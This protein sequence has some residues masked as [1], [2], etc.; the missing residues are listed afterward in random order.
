MPLRARH[1]HAQPLHVGTGVFL[2]HVFD[3]AA[4]QTARRSSRT[5][6]IATW[7]GMV[8]GFRFT[9]DP[10]ANNQFLPINRRMFFR[11]SMVECYASSHLSDSSGSA[12]HMLTSFQVLFGCM[13]QC[14]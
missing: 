7:Q 5:V 14:V 11:H 6:D 10:K 1:C 3:G 13:L 12:G 4:V 8:E 9:L 2:E